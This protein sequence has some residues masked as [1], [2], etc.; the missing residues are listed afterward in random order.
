MQ[1]LDDLLEKCGFVKQNN[2]NYDF[3]TI[4]QNIG[5][6]LPADYKYYLNNY[7]PFDDWIGEQYVSLYNFDTVI[8]MNSF[9]TDESMNN[10]MRLS[11]TVAI[12]SN[13][14]SE[15]IGLRSMS[16]LSFLAVIGQYIYDLDD[17]IKIGISFTDMVQRLYNGADW[18]K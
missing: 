2:A 10:Q 7:E 13:G 17:H 4:E 15:I 16:D 18:F 3:L 1:E 11:K 9:V 8:Q 5:F 6:S 14:A 12:G